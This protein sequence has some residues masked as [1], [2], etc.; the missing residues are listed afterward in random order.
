V[1]GLCPAALLAPKG[2]RWASHYPNDRRE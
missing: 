2:S 1:A